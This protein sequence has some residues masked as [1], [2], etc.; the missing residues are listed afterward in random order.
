MEYYF[1]TDAFN[2]D[3]K[4]NV[5]SK[6]FP[7][8]NNHHQTLLS[9]KLIN[10]IDVIATKFNFDIKNK[11]KYE[12][13]FRQNN[14]RDAV[15]LLLL[16]LPFI[17]D[18][19]GSKKRSLRSLDELYVKKKDMG[20]DINL[21]EP[22]YE[23]T[24]IQYGR[25]KRIK[26]KA[27]EI[28]FSEEHLQHNY[29]LLL[30]TIKTVAYK[31][32]VNWVNIRPVDPGSIG[33]LPIL[34]E[35]DDLI[36]NHKITTWDPSDDNKTARLSKALDAS[37]IYNV[38]SNYL[39][40]EIRRIRWTIYE[41]YV[42]DKGY[43]YIAILNKFINIE[44]AA[45]NISWNLLN[46]NDKSDFSRQWNSWIDALQ[47]KQT[48]KDIPYEQIAYSMKIIIT[49]FDS[50][51]RN[52]KQAKS[53][54]Y[55]PLERG[56][57]E[58]EITEDE[59]EDISNIDKIK[60]S[61]VSLRSHPEHIYEYIRYSFS[62]LRNTWYGNYYFKLNKDTNTYELDK[63]ESPAAIE[64]GEFT[65][66]N[67]YNY[68]E[69]LI[70]YTAGNVYKKYPKLWK[71]LDDADKDVVLERLNWSGGN[72]D[73]WFKITRYLR[74]IVGVQ[75]GDVNAK[76][77]EIHDNI[78]K[79][80]A[81]IIFD[82]MAKIG[83]LSEFDPDPRLTDYAV[84]PPSTKERYDAIQRLLG[85]YVMNNSKLRKK[86]EDAIYFIN[87]QTYGSLEL[88]LKAKTIKYLDALTDPT[89]NI[90]N[91][92]SMYA[93]DWISQ[94]SFYHHYLNNRIIYI[95]GGTGVGKSSQAPKL[96][97]YALKMLDY[98]INGTVVGSQP[99]IQPTTDNAKTISL[100]MGIPIESYNK[101]VDKDIRSDNYFV[102]Y[103]Y[104][105]GNH[106]RIQSGLV[107]KIMT[108]GMLETQLHNPVLKKLYGDKF[109][110][111]N[112]YDIVMVD[113][114]HEHNTNMDLILTR[115]K[116]AAYFNND[117]KL[118]IISA[119]M[120]EDEA[121]YRRY[122][123][124]I[125]D[126]KMYPLNRALVKHNLDRINVDRR[127]HISP[128]GEATLYKIEEFYKPNDDPINVVINIINTTTDGDILLFEP[129]VKGIR[130]AVEAINK[131]TPQNTTAV[132]YYSELADEKRRFIEKIST[133]KYNLTISKDESFNE[134]DL[135]EKKVTAGTY[136]RVIIVAT[137]IAEASITVPS[138][139]FVV[140][141]GL[142]KVSR[143]DYK[144]RGESLPEEK[145]SEQARIQRKG[146][147]GRV[148]NGQVY[149]IYKQGDMEK[150]RKQYEISLKD[151][152][153]KLL[154]MLYE[155]PNEQPYFTENNDPNKLKQL[156]IQDA[157]KIYLEGLSAMVTKQYF[158]KNFYSYD[159]N[160]NH[161]DYDNDQMPF[162]YYQTG[163]DKS[164]LDDKT[165]TFY[166]IHPDEL[167][168][169]RN[170]LGKIVDIREECKDDMIKEAKN[171]YESKKID[172]FW[173]ILREQLFVITTKDNIAFKTEFGQ[174][175]NKIKQNL[176]KLSVKHI[177]SLIY[178]RVYG[179][180][181]DM[182]KLVAMYLTINS[183]RDIV[184]YGLVE[185]KPR[186][187]FDDAMKLYGNCT[188]DSNGLIKIANEI[189]EFITKNIML[190]NEPYTIKELETQKKLFIT[191]H[192]NQIDSELLDTFTQLKNSNNLTSQESLT[193]KE[194]D[195]LIANDTLI[196][197]L[198]AKLKD[199]KY[200][201]QIE[202]WSK[203]RYLKSENILKFL[204]NYFGLLNDLRKYDK[205]LYE[206]DEEITT[207]KYIELTWF[208]THT[209]KML[210]S[211]EVNKDNCISVA[212]LHGFG[213]SLIKNIAIMNDVYYYI[214]MFNP[215]LDYVYKINKLFVPQYEVRFK[216]PNNTFLKY[217]CL[218][219][220]LLYISK[221]E[222]EDTGD[223]NIFLIEN[224]E[225]NI[226]SKVLPYMI[227]NN[228][229]K[230]QQEMYVKEFLN[231]IIINKE[232]NTIYN[233]LISKYLKTIEE[234]RYDLFNFQDKNAFEKLLVVD[235][236]P[237]VKD[238]LKQTYGESRI[239]S[240]GGY[241]IIRSN[242]YFIEALINKYGLKHLV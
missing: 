56:T 136:K 65:I 189:L 85:Q 162:L 108:D 229:D 23:Y 125:N 25:C 4:K 8:L 235:T 14:Y 218:R 155:N 118:I 175:I 164:T 211:S 154:D 167:C 102:Q 224:I 158:I 53:D 117:V 150:N 129:G 27:E 126:N 110:S 199:P 17:D 13:Q 238:A 86:W 51:Y 223:E 74:K 60:N 31:L 78:Q 181:N 114:A 146:R 134:A 106:E 234:I 187:F 79:N 201:N 44:N 242:Y 202:Q 226:I 163:F 180:Y 147:V 72:V 215:N 45:K 131:R 12:H 63:T 140:D 52:L 184:Y 196:K 197:L 87:N 144:L 128:P 33:T 2:S 89:L 227:Q 165:G 71:S 111:E 232:G 35:T 153:D 69:S 179:C 198:N 21:H 122:Y 95:T 80:L 225:N 39:F 10:V 104:R 76:N 172:S 49:Y 161:Y 26:D 18:I 169:K 124:E 115:M 170:I 157:R 221:K 81:S 107:L 30:D 209:P 1:I 141:T 200:I 77:Q 135:K 186:Y 168:L 22:K 230:V 32:Y 219:S 42:K 103:K 231:K 205:E 47:Q 9:D 217:T 191:K 130:D 98:K 185:G 46:T 194:I 15:G 208:D 58:E 91:W 160:K 19:N 11:A 193:R 73:S 148:A 120:E 176:V 70:S 50:N 97:L 24:N 192:Y 138:L 123:R 145:I 40:Y 149:Y 3:I 83:V 171:V 228:Y 62:E 55:V 82:V 236:R 182:I 214:N 239:Q 116:Y 183:T 204:R 37:E 88:N 177:I 121:T 142:Q 96:F 105:E 156:T 212:L 173:E 137:N 100:Q 178:G 67:V 195:K 151:L 166:I 94:I 20:Q 54:G 213:Y 112:I 132:P 216:I 240:G 90:G 210:D 29:L 93:M 101:D 207:K 109:S 237:S 222:D 127:I 159:G 174:N 206:I 139:R 75:R 92:I 233:K 152:T 143:Y 203:K 188:G 48:Y 61:A 7:N 241:G 220:T 99:R 68:T 59:E 5:I 38:L 16:L 66:K 43:K 84:L 113:E 41:I 34:K 119:T 190:T 36:T 57:E 133:N 6:T 28:K 64:T